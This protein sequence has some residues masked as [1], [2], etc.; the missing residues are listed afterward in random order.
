M[1]K[2]F[3]NVEN[4]ALETEFHLKNFESSYKKN[5]VFESQCYFN[6]F[7]SATRSMTM[8][9]QFVMKDTEDFNEWYKEQTSRLK[10]I[11]NLQFFVNFRNDS[12]HQG[13]NFVFSADWSLNSEND[14]RELE[15]FFKP[16]SFQIFRSK[17]SKDIL[18]A[19][20][21]YFT[22]L[23]RVIQQCYVKYGAIIDPDQYW[24]IKNIES[25]RLTC[26]DV[27]ESMG[28][29]RG[30]TGISKYTERERKKFL[31]QSIRSRE[32]ITCP[33]EPLFKNY[34]GI[35]KMGEQIKQKI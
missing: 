6:A 8:V 9:L 10:E 35:N 28:F 13:K 25:K 22:A 18:N 5:K 11:K 31:I 15:T 14:E 29:P 20:R 1:S 7:L 32:A 26:E 21:E 33:L 17:I 27:E 30:W 19:S 23:L 16:E 12:I 3:G 34:L 24:T 2:N 4:K